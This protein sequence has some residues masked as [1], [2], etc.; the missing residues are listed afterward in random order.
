MTPFNPAHKHYNI[1][2]QFIK[3]CFK[4]PDN[5]PFIESKTKG[6]TWAKVSTPY[7]NENYEYRIASDIST[8]MCT[9]MV[10]YPEPMRTAPKLNTYVWVLSCPGTSATMNWTGTASQISML[11]SGHCFSSPD[12]VNA[13]YNALFDSM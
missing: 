13:C 2:K 9:R 10:T 6:N 11:H 7:W 12:K 4:N 1:H 5:P 8:D 3:A